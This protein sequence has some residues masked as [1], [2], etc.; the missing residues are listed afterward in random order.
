M[1]LL[2]ALI[3]AVVPPLCA[4][5]RGPPG[6]L[7]WLCGACSERLQVF[8]GSLCLRCG[9]P[10]PVQAPVC[11]SCPPWPKRFCGLRAAAPHAGAA[12][13]LV[14]ALRRRH[15]IAVARPLGAL[16]TAV[17][18]G[19]PLPDDVVIVAVPMDRRRRVR[20][21][22]NH[23]EEIARVVAAGLGRPRR[24]GLLRRIRAP[25]CIAHRTRSG[26]FRELRRGTFRA[27]DAAKGQSVLLVDDTVRTGATIGACAGAL[28]ARGA[29]E[30]WAVAATRAP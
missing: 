1:R 5:C 16:V 4:L 19:L 26:R 10:R 30:V 21:G 15:R 3:D 27:S 7:P 17:A 13:Q 23:A 11:G 8:S 20:Q 12:R 22:Y 24:P 2:D 29:R 18:R 6:E 25:A 28:L 9:S 14:Q